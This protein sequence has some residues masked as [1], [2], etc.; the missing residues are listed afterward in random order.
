MQ[1]R[2]LCAAV[3]LAAFMVATTASATVH[4]V[5]PGES[6]QAAIDVAAPGDTILVE[7]G[8]YEFTGTVYAFG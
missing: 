6:I 4:R 7:P 3:G 5:Y 1:L 2:H 8:K